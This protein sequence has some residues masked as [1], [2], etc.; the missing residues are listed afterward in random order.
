MKIN[1]QFKVRTV[2]GENIVVN[3]GNL[4]ADKTKIIVL[5]EV[6]LWLW[7]K[8]QAQE[9]SLADASQALV[10][11][12]EI[13]ADQAEADAQKWICELAKAGLLL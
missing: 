8:F 3:F 2:A 10:A 9:F 12:Y 5:N 1:P 6:A 7:N 4:N 13:P 11:E